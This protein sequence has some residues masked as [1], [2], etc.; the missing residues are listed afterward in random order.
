MGT[1][2]TRTLSR[3]SKSR[4]FTLIEIS[5]AMV[6]STML[7]I[8]LV[9]LTLQAT[10]LANKSD[11]NVN[12]FAKERRAFSSIVQDITRADMVLVQGKSPAGVNWG[13]D[14]TSTLV[15]RIPRTGGNFDYVIY[16]REAQAGV[17]G[18]NVLRLYQGTIT[19]G[20]MSNSRLVDTVAENVRSFSLEY[21][22]IDTF[23]GDWWTKSYTLRTLP[24]SPTTNF[25]ITAVVG[26][27]DRLAD[28]YATRNGQIINITY[29]MKG[30]V[31]MDVSYPISPNITA[32]SDGG[33]AASSV[34]VKLEVEP[35]WK[36]ARQADRS[37]IIVLKSI[38]SLR[39][40]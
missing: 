26:G 33:N 5:V 40:R 16:R 19:G 17:T 29:A 10:R 4:G 27:S 23:W 8:F 34:M 38:A 30:G 15:L 12:V 7:V 37:K 3:N 14:G 32:N 20:V 2:R 11:S 22:A 1:H 18:P 39:N 9:N 31:T 25:P 35:V 6:I 28:G 21:G 13:T 24:L 36:D